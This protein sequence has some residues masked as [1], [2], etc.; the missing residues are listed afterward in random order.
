VFAQNNSGL[1]ITVGE[2][3]RGVAYGGVP[4]PRVPVVRALDASG[5]PRNAADRTTP[6]WVQTKYDTLDS[7]IPLASYDEAQLIIAEGVGGAEAVGI[8]NALHSRA[9]LPPFAATN[10]T[11]IQRQVIE[12]RRRELFIEGQRFF[13]LW[14]YRDPASPLYQALVPAPGTPYPKGGSYQDQRCM[15]LP[16][17]ERLNNPNIPDQVAAT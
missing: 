6:L 3:Y 5:R 8:I 10:E 7:P 2:A 12:E 9:G 4:D 17:V 16:D 1:A 15:P 11:E 14:R 13:D